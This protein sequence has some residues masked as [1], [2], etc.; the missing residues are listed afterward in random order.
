MHKIFDIHLHTPNNLTDALK[1]AWILVGYEI[2]AKDG[3]KGLKV[4][5]M[6][7]RMAKSKSSFYHHFADLEVFTEALLCYHLQQAAVIA[8]R[9]RQ[10]KNVVPELLNVLLDVKQDLFFNRQL[11][12]NRHI[13]AFKICFEKASQDVAEATVAI[14]ADALGLT[15]QTALAGITLNLALENF[16]LQITEET[17]NYEWLQSYVKEMRRMVDEFKKMKTGSFSE[18]E[19][20]KAEN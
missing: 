10:C 1:Q 3:P 19:F 16:Y 17:L 13:L 4:E 6:A 14:W 20:P 8:A 15:D 9:E 12:V 7:R 18:L 2:F 5:V 11:R